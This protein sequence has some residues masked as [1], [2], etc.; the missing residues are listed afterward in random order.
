MRVYIFLLL[1]AV[2]LLNAETL[3]EVK[4]SADNP[5]LNVSTDGLR[6]MNE[7]DTLMVISSEA[8]RANIGL[9]NKGLSRAFSVTTTQSKGG[10]GVTNAFEVGADSTK[11]GTVS[12]TMGLGGGKYTD[13]NPDNIFI[14][15]NTGNSELPG[16]GNV[17]IGNDVGTNASN[18]FYSTFIGA[19]A[20]AN[21]T[22]GFRNTFV[23]YGCGQYNSD[24]YNNTFYG[25]YSGRNNSTG[26]YNNFFGKDSGCNNT[27]GHSN[28]TFGY[29]A[30]YGANGAGYNYNSI[31]GTHAARLLTTGSSN[32]IMGYYSAY[33]STTGS[34]NVYIGEKSGHENQ[35]GSG[36]IFLGYN[37]GYNET[38]SNKLYIDNS[39]T[40]FPLIYGQFDSRMCVIDGT[41]SDNPNNRKLFVNGTAGG[42]T[43]WYNDSDKRLKKN[44]ETIDSALDK[45]M[46]LRGVSFEWDGGKRYQT[47]KS[48]GF[49][50]Q[51]AIEVVPELVDYNQENDS[52][53]MQYAPVTALLVEAVKEQNRE[54]QSL[55]DMN[56][57]LIRELKEIRDQL[58][59]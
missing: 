42:T 3:F 1:I 19:Y 13:F 31:F 44:I 27:T 14:G 38:G 56:E 7:G 26:Y 58:E 10:K 45:V 16:T 30:G 17:F 53:G 51:E 33:R 11:I 32:V 23:G 6:V 52:Y 36:N 18:S 5:V 35:T 4:D 46:K 57:K 47:G 49:I 40:T 34:N 48:I 43:A 22:G 9:T 20:G 29:G 54:I 41:A 59:E 55:K 50:A 28:S 12:T 25:D 39:G 8:I 15:L 21:A 37:A 2:I 24:G